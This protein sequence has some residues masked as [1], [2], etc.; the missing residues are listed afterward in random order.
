[1]A[2]AGLVEGD[3]GI[4]R[5]Q[6]RIIDLRTSVASLVAVA[7]LPGDVVVNA[8]VLRVHLIVFVS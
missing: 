4:C 6:G 8:L 5:L 3:G 2:A 7:Q 1:M